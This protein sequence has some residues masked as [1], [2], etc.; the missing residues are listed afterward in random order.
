MLSLKL[1]ILASVL[2]GLINVNN[3]SNCEAKGVHITLGD[4]FAMLNCK[5][6]YFFNLKITKH[7]KT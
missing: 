5:I 6:H 1:Y 2:F 3:S 7:Q 4:R